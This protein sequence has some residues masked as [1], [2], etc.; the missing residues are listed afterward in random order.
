MHVYRDAAMM[1]VFRAFDKDGSGFLDNSEL[2]GNNHRHA[3]IKPGKLKWQLK[4]VGKA[5]I[6]GG[7]QFSTLIRFVKCYSNL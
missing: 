4:I 6:L 7:G 5:S 3:R 2:K 1:G